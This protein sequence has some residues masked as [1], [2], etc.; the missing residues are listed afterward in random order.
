MVTPQPDGTV[1]TQPHP[2]PVKPPV[3]VPP[4][5]TPPAATTAWAEIASHLESIAQRLRTL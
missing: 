3:V 5:V 1:T 2:D 4:V